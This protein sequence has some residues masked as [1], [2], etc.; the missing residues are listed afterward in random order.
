MFW[1]IYIPRAMKKFKIAVLAVFV[2]LFF[3]FPGLADNGN[4]YFVRTVLDGDTIILANN[5]SVR[6][7]GIDTPELRK[8][9]NN[10]WVYDPKPYAVEAQMLN[11]TLVQ[12]KRIKLEFDK[13]ISD[14][15]GRWLAYVFVGDKM[16]NEELLRSGYAVIYRKTINV[17]Y[18]N[19]LKKA[20]QEAKDKKIGLFSV[21]AKHAR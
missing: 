12:G 14:K 7:I 21:G 17:K 9:V 13:E 18:L 20:E 4:F 6:Y 3:N 19:R 15:Y 8:K 5:K 2:F 16:V 11:K 10:K 1:I